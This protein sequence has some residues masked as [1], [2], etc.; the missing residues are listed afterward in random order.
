MV[1]RMPQRKIGWRAALG[2]VAFVLALAGGVVAHADD[3]DD[4]NDDRTLA[5]KAADRFPQPIQV[6]A[7]LNRTVL[8][9]VESQTK[10]GTVKTIVRAPD[11]TIEAVVEYGGFWGFG[12]RPIAVPIDAMVLLGLYMEIV[13][14]DPGELKAFPTF[15]ASG[16]TPLPRDMIIKVGLGKPA[17]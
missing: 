2:V 6:G 3:D 13:D 4:D 16:T 14:F 7:L 8:E 10:L 15:E 1:Q 9:P 12:A 11:K 5:Q 17:H